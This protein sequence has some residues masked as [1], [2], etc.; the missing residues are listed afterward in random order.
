MVSCTDT[1][2]DGYD[3]FS[4]ALKKSVARNIVGLGG[5]LDWLS[6]GCGWVWGLFLCVI[7]CVGACSPVEVYR[8]D[9]QVT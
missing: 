8:Q 1:A 7:V 5:A 2:V 4:H 6:C 9:F 3:V